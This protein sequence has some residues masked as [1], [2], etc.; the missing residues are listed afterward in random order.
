MGIA[1]A[2]FVYA[3]V[4]TKILFR[5]SETSSKLTKSMN[6]N[7]H[8]YYFYSPRITLGLL[9][10]YLHLLR[11]KAYFLTFLSLFTSI[12]LKDLRHIPIYLIYDACITIHLLAISSVPLYHVSSLFPIFIQ[13]PSLSLYYGNE[14]V[15]TQ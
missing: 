14:I 5:P 13:H 10:I 8:E 1:L 9:P 2:Y 4:I 3:S 12:I 15:A 7:S 6:T 11:S